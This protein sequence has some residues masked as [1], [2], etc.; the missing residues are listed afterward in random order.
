MRLTSATGRLLAVLGRLVSSTA[1]WT[2]VR[3]G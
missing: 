1:G 3:A 2:Q